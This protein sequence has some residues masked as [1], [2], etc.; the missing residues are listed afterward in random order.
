MFKE[1]VEQRGGDGC[2]VERFETFSRTYIHL[3]RINENHAIAYFALG[4]SG[5]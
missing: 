3:T 1:L 2:G 5:R 4:V